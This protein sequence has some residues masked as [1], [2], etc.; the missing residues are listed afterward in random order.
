MLAQIVM[1]NTLP[2]EV[3]PTHAMGKLQA[4]PRAENTGQADR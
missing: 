4:D 2:Y 3:W 1:L